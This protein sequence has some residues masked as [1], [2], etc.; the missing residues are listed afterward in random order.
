MG[1]IL[2]RLL[3]RQGAGSAR[4]ECLDEESLAIYVS[5]DLTDSR[6]REIEEHLVACPLCL[7]EIAAAYRATQ[8][9]EVESVRERVL[10]RAMALVPPSRAESNILP[11]TV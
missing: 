7:D 4:N 5:G 9:G 11:I 8:P 2:K 1:W 6:R 3:L 10:R